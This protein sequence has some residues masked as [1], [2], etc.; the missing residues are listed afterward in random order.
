MEDLIMTDYKLKTG[1]AGEKIVGAYKRLE[2]ELTDTFLE[3]DENSESGYILKTGKVAGK[4]VSKYK[5][6]ENRVISGYKAIENG[7]VGEYRKIEDK[8]VDTFLEKTDEKESE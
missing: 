3:A 2:K 7:V 8:F 4:V 1:K 6:I 5:K